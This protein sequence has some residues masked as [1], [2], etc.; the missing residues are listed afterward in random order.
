[1]DALDASEAE[2]APKLSPSSVPVPQEAA[3]LRSADKNF[4]GGTLGSSRPPL[5]Y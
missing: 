3:F 2:G 5:Y 1:M 4:K